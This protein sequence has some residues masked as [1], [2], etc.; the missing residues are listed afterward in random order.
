[1]TDKKAQL[2]ELLAVEADLTNT[3]KAMLE[4][5]ANTFAKKPDHF[6]GFVKSLTYFDET[7]RSEDERGEKALVTTVSDKLNYA[8]NYAARLYDAVLQKEEANQRANADLVVDGTTIGTNLPATF[9]LGL[10][11]RLKAVQQV[12]LAIPTLDPAMIWSEDAGAGDGIYRAEPQTAKRGEKQVRS[13]V[14]YEATK[15][16]PAQ[17]E[18]WNED[19]AVAKIETVHTSA[20][21]TPRKKA[22]V[23]G[24]LDK[25]IRATKKA[26]QRANTVE[27]SNLRVGKALFDYI[28]GE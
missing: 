19:V 27:V 6:K 4:E 21:W 8:T 9:L 23:L 28:Q 26:R 12:L 15:E 1:M 10:E 17:I 5:A 18:K 20:M 14:L 13:K 7:R 22:D 2:H 24:R 3:T 25:L 11:S 16:H